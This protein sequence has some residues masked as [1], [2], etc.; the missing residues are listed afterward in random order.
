MNDNNE[1]YIIFTEKNGKKTINDLNIN[2]FLISNKKQF[3]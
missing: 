3:Y 1:K 2:I